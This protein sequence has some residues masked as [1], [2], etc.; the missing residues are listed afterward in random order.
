MMFDWKFRLGKF[1]FGWMS[2]RIALPEKR[3]WKFFWQRRTRGWS[4][5]E[6]WCL[7]TTIAKFV[8][9]RLKRFREIDCG[10]P[11][12]LK[13][14]EWETILDKMIFSFEQIVSEDSDKRLDGETDGQ[15]Q[16]RRSRIREGLKLFGKWFQALWW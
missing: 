8:L 9:P 10:Y 4:D 14:K 1:K 12:G 5:D 7:D 11:G 13:E 16:D 6:T 3:D 2:F 15:Y